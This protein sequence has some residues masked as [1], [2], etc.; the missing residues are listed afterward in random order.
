MIAPQP[1]YDVVAFQ[2]EAPLWRG[3]PAHVAVEN[4]KQAV[5]C[6]CDRC[7]SQSRLHG[8]GIGRSAEYAVRMFLAEIIV[9]HPSHGLLGFRRESEEFVFETVGGFRLIGPI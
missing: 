9:R 6:R 8:N 4:V 2:R 3:L 1:L 7:E 5:R